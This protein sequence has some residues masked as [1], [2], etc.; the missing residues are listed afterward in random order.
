MCYWEHCCGCLFQPDWWC[1]HILFSWAGKQMQDW[2]VCCNLLFFSVWKKLEIELVNVTA[3]GWPSGW[4]KPFVQKEH[5]VNQ[6]LVLPWKPH[7]RS[8]SWTH[9]DLCIGNTCSLHIQH[10]PQISARSCGGKFYKPELRFT[11]CKLLYAIC[12]LNI[13]H[14]T[15]FIW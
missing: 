13:L 5:Y 9:I 8:S 15:C 3:S 14:F 7:I 12:E 6:G 2:I 1:I 11:S 4:E 10:V